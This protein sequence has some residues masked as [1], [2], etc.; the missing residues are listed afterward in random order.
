LRSLQAPDSLATGKQFFEFLRDRSKTHRRSSLIID[1]IWPYPMQRFQ[2]AQLLQAM[3]W[4]TYQ[5]AQQALWE[6]ANIERD[7]QELAPVPPFDQQ[8]IKDDWLQWQ[9]GL[10]QQYGLQGVILPND[11]I[12][13]A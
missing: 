6:H 13:L 9:T 8:Q 11:H 7:M 4:R 2:A 10:I 1:P 12:S 5:V 3:D